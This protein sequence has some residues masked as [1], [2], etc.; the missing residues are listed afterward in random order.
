MSAYSRVARHIGPRLKVAQ[1]QLNRIQRPPPSLTAWP[2]PCGRGQPSRPAEPRRALAC[3]ARSVWSRSGSTA[4][5]TRM[6]RHTLGTSPSCRPW[7]R[8]PRRSRSRTR[9]RARESSA[10][11]KAGTAAGR[12]ARSRTF[13]SCSSASFR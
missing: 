7:E 2:P 5:P 3:S 13:G 11:R 10:A 4:C 9:P 1:R 12:S 6:S 8:R